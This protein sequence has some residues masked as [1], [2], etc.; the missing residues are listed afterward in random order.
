MTNESSFFCSSL[1]KRHSRTFRASHF[2]TINTKCYHVCLFS[3]KWKVKTKSQ[4]Q[5]SHRKSLDVLNDF[6][7]KLQRV[8]RKSLYFVSTIANYWSLSSCFKKKQRYLN[9][10]I[11]SKIFALKRRITHRSLVKESNDANKIDITIILT[12]TFCEVKHLKNIETKIAINEKFA[13]SNFFQSSHTWMQTFKA[14]SKESFA[15]SSFA[16]VISLFFEHNEISICM[17]F[18][19]SLFT[20]TLLILYAK[21]TTSSAFDVTKAIVIVST[22]VVEI[23]YFRE[24]QIYSRWNIELESF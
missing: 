22:F 7:M 20:M 18:K 14:L 12:R 6:S 9:L 21:L 5:R 15:S 4:I 19:V 23:L 1:L 10:R 17:M 13:I 3:R 2:F 16:T 8:N 24:N 11:I